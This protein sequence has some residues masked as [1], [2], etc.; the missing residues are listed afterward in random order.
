MQESLPYPVYACQRKVR[1][2]PSEDSSYIYRE[3]RAQPPT[4]ITAAGL[5]IE[6]TRRLAA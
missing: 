5:R 6:G 2:K 1:R 4:W 3:H